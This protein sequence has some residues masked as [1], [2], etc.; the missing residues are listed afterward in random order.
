MRAD[1]APQAGLDQ[2]L[3]QTAVGEVVRRGQM[4]IRSRLGQ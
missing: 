1:V 3:R 4:A 2:R